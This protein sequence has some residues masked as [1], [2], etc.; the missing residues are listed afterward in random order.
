MPTRARIVGYG[1]SAGVVL[2]GVVAAVFVAGVTGQ[3]LAFVLIALGFVLAI[4]LV[5]YEVGLSE[6][7]ERARQARPPRRAR[8]HFRLGRERDHSRRLR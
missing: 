3:V 2:L 7:R 5:F 6:D 4:S 8:P 1:L